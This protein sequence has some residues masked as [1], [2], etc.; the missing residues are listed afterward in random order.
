MKPF[1]FLG[2]ITVQLFQNKRAQCK[3]SSLFLLRSGDYFSLEKVQHVLSKEMRKYM[4]GTIFHVEKCLPQM[5][6][7]SLIEIR[8]S[9]SRKN[10]YFFHTLIKNYLANQKVN[11]T[12]LLE[13]F[14]NNY[15]HPP[16]WYR[17]LDLILIDPPQTLPEDIVLY[18]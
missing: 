5:A 18:N 14:W 2:N 9:F 11:N 7:A 13:S 1:E 10:V 16:F 8:K 17:K 15:F 4:A 6:R 12:L 3:L